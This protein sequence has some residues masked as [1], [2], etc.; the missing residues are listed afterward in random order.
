MFRWLLKRLFRIPEPA[1]PP[2]LLR[3]LTVAEA[4]I[5]QDVVVVQDD[6]WCITCGEEDRTIRLFEVPLPDAEQC[7]LTYRAKLKTEGVGG[8]AYL[9]GWC[10]LPG[11]GEFFSRG[12][13]HTVSGTNDWAS[14]E[15]PFF[16]KR[17]QKADLFKLNIVVEGGGRIW[18]KGVEVLKTPLKD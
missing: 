9:E 11:Q 12:L 7:I 4:T 17:G 10:R 18:I 16:L 3:A 6:A 1:G 8:R 5:N 2:Q 13:N 15:T 14:Y